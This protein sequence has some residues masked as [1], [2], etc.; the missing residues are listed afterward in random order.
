M[1]RFSWSNWDLFPGLFEEHEMNSENVKDKDS[2]V[3][4]LNPIFKLEIISRYDEINWVR[5]KCSMGPV[6]QRGGGGRGEGG[7]L[8]LFGQCPYGNNILQKGA[9]LTPASYTIIIRNKLHNNHSCYRIFCGKNIAFPT[10]NSI[11]PE[12]MIHRVRQIQRMIDK[13]N[14]P[15]VRGC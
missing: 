14:I 15:R 2:K 13:K 1:P 6:W 9:S 8:K 11:N 12:W 4:T 10:V 3:I 5:K 7:P